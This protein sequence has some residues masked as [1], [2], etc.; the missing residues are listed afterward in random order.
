[1]WITHSWASRWRPLE[2]ALAAVGAQAEAVLECVA[3]ETDAKRPAPIDIES[4][5]AKVIL[6]LLI[7]SYGLRLTHAPPPRVPVPAGPRVRR[8]PVLEAAACG[9]G[10]AVAVLNSITRQ[11]LWLG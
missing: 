11:F 6:S 4:L 8:G 7:R 1:M 9:H 3:D 5:L 10:G 2:G